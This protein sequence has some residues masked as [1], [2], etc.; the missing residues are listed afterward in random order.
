M[1]CVDPKFAWNHGDFQD[2]IG[3]TWLGIVGP[4]VKRL[5]V[6]NSIW[7]DHADDRPTMLSLLGLSD[8]YVMDGRVITQVLDNGGGHGNSR[9]LSDNDHGD[10]TTELG[11]VYKQLNAPYGAFGLDTLVASTTAIKS[12]DELVYDSIETKIANLTSPGT[13]SPGRF[14]P[15]STT[16][17]SE[18]ATS[19]RARRGPGSNRRRA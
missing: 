18:A 7:A 13:C 4:G 10:T 11:N 1:L 17:R 19:I 12:T 2:E 5:G 8:S 16:R 3:N 9:R 14:A 15:R 6:N